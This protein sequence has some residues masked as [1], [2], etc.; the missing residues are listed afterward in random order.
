MFFGAPKIEASFAEPHFTIPATGPIQGQLIPIDLSSE[1]TAI[2]PRFSVP[3]PENTT[4]GFHRSLNPA[5]ELVALAML[6]SQADESLS[7]FDF[8]PM[9]GCRDNHFRSAN[10]PE[11]CNRV[12]SLEG[13]TYNAPTRINPTR[14]YPC[15]HDPCQY[16]NPSWRS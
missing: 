3:L 11:E 2:Y 1:A 15:S 4:S 5:Q 8:I 12:Y 10:T 7:I 9:V 14:R 13:S 6:P 16:T